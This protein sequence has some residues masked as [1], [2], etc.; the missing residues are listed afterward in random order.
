MFRSAVKGMNIPKSEEGNSIQAMQVQ[1]TKTQFNSRITMIKTVTANCYLVV[2]LIAISRAYRS[3]D[4][5]KGHRVGLSDY[6]SSCP[7]SHRLI[8]ISRTNQVRK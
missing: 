4:L 3:I 2:Q 1:N 6:F 7:T 5:D 8:T